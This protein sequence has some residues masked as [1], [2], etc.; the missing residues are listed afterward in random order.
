MTLVRVRERL[1]G[2][3]LIRCMNGPREEMGRITKLIRSMTLTAS[4]I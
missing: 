2:I 4:V 3:G 1:R